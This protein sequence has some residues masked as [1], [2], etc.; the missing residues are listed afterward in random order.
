MDRT[1][2]FL[3]FAEASGRPQRQVA[4]PSHSSAALIS[5]IKE[6][7]AHLEKSIDKGQNSDKHIIQKIEDSLQQLYAL[8]QPA[9]NQAAAGTESEMQQ[10]ITSNIRR[11]YASLSLTLA[12]ILRKEQK[13]RT[14]LDE[15]EQRARR[16][17]AHSHHTGQ[18]IYQEK[19]R[20]ILREEASS[21]RK[22]ELESIETH[23]NELGKVITEVS[24]HISM[25]GEQLERIDELFSK[26]K[27]ALKKG[28]FE[29]NHAL[30]AVSKRRRNI[31][32][33][34]V[35][36]FGLLFLIRSITR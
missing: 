5:E 23:I 7:L 32:I 4:A 8:T 9:G 34:F 24:M 29:L 11:Q 13:I 12:N 27:V 28:S 6:Q 1:R 18:Q 31:I 15:E 19:Q 30:A 16:P 25:Q 22:R 21:L 33:L 26:S 3:L 35:L 36:L 10:K 14:A 2:E 20:E 17:P